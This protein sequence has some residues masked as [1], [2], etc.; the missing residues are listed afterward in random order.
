MYS[1]AQV[2]VADRLHS[3][4]FL[5]RLKISFV[6]LLNFSLFIFLGWRVCCALAPGTLTFDL[7]TSIRSRLFFFRFLCLT[8]AVVTT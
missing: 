4:F 5:S 1:F 2:R 6:L 7:P 8:T 3:V